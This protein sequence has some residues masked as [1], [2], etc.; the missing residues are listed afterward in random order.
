MWNPGRVTL[1]GLTLTGTKKLCYARYA[2]VQKIVTTMLL[3]NDPKIIKGLLL[4]DMRKVM[5]TDSVKKFLLRDV[6]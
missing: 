4:S 3:L 6:L 1:I 5:T 2:S